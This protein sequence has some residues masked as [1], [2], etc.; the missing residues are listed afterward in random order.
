[1]VDTVPPPLE[2][3]SSHFAAKPGT[4]SWPLTGWDE[5][6]VNGAKVIIGNGPGGS[7]TGGS[8]ADE[9]V[10]DGSTAGDKVGGGGVADRAITKGPV[11]G[12]GVGMRELQEAMITIPAMAP[13]ITSQNFLRISICL[14]LSRKIWLNPIRKFRMSSHF[15]GVRLRTLRVCCATAHT[16][17]AVLP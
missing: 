16:Q 15:E 10:A 3:G 2:S 9:R 1:M 5:E 14:L 6:V 7:I 11:V 8:V 13:I 12:L 4:A 17:N